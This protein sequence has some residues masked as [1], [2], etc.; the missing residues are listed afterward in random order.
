MTPEE[1]AEAVNRRICWHARS[2]GLSTASISQSNRR[3]CHQLSG[4]HKTTVLLDI[5]TNIELSRLHGNLRGVTIVTREF[6]I[7]AR[8]RSR[9]RKCTVDAHRKPQL[10][11]HA[12]LSASIRRHARTRSWEAARRG[13]FEFFRVQLIFAHARTTRRNM[14]LEI[15]LRDSA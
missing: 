3:R 1:I 15:T 9:N 11:V 10:R 7:I 2:C 5:E 13:E 4:D 8:E 14:F 6:L 12:C